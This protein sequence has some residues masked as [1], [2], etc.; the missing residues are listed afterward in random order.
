MVMKDGKEQCEGKK[1]GLG[2]KA[3]GVKYGSRNVSFFFWA[4]SF[5][6]LFF[7][8]RFLSFS[9]GFLPLPQVFV[10]FLDFSYLSTCFLS[11]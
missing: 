8:A 11:F 2:F 4:F 7:F 10:P 9:Q 1:G 6:S 3:V 5:F